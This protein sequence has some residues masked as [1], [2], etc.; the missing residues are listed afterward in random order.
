MVLF[1]FTATLFA[2]IKGKILN[3]K[4]A[5]RCETMEKMEEAIK[6]DPTL[7]QQWK[8]Q[9]EKEYNA[10]LQRQSLQKG[11]KTEA[12]EIIIPVVFH[13]VDDSATLSG[14]TDRD[15]YEQVEILN[16]AYNGNKGD[17]YQGVIPQEIYNRLG[18]I[19]LKFVLA[20][21]T[22]S[23]NLTNGIERRVNTSPDHISIKSYSSGGLD[24]WDNTKYVNVWC[25]T[26]SGSDIGLL[27]IA[28]FPFTT[29]E[30]PQGV[31]ISI[32][33]LPYT[34]SN[35]RSYYPA[36]AEGGTLAHE[37]GHYFYL[38]HTFGDQTVCNN[39]DFR[40]QSGWPL[41][42]GAG[43]EGDDTPEEKAGP[44]N[45]YFGDPSMNYS[46]GCASE[47]FGEMYGSFMNYFDDRAMFM[48]SDGMRKRVEGCIDLYRPGLLTT[49]GATPPVAVTDAFLVTVTP[50][51]IPERKAYFINNSPFT[52]TVRNTGTS[53]MNS[54]TLNVKLD[55][56]SPV[57]TV[58]PLNLA[59]G[60]DTVLNLG[61][62]NS[63]LGTH[64]MTIYTTAPNNS[65]DAFTDNDTIQSFIYLEGSSITAPFTESFSSNTF[66]PTGWQI[67]NP[68]TNNT[69]AYSSSSGYSLAG[70]AT[71][72]NFSY[73]G[74]G[75][76]DDLISPP[77][78]L[79]SADS[80]VLSFR[81]A[82]AVYDTVD[83]STWDGLE[84]YVSGDGGVTYHL[85]YKKS[86]DQLKTLSAAQT[87]AF[88]AFPSSPGNWRLENI[89][90]TPFIIP[91]KKVI[92]KFRNINGY[93][94]NTYIDDVTVSV[95]KLYNRDVL[96]VSI[97]ALPDLLCGDV[98]T[99]TVTLLSNGIDSLK[100]M[101]VNYQLDN[102]NI[103]IINWTGLLLKG[104]QVGVPLNTL[105]GLTVGNHV[106]T[107]YTSDPN[108][109]ADDVTA[110]DT[111][112][113]SF[114]VFGKV[115]TPISEGFEG[116]TFPPANWGISNQDGGITWE[117]TTNVAKTGIGSMVI[118]NYDNTISSTQKFISSIVSGTSANDSL[119]VSFDYAYAQGISSSK[120]DTLDLQITTDCGQT[121]TS[122]W[123]KWGTDLQTLADPS[124][125]TGARFT[126]L[127]NDW[128]NAKIDLS[129]FIGND[130]QV[131]FTSRENEQ[132]N[133]YIDNINIYGVIVPARLKNQGYLIYP[134]P[135]RQQFIIRNYEV[136]V[137]F[138]SASVY[139]SV[140]QLVWTKNYNGTANKEE[141][142]DLSNQARGIY[143]V[144]L[145]YTD[146][147][148][149]QRIVKD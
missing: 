114:Y 6:K 45:A 87:S 36:Y 8:I 120:P 61:N 88:A 138:Q 130:F 113:K 9:G 149:V 148:I 20:K 105:N 5:H 111:I 127:P 124:T 26:F 115:S 79:G 116:V 123:K 7:P 147:T 27:G 94:N 51:G 117:R 84:V 92:V 71:V 128:M 56:A 141:T 78:D 48:F 46:D 142:V 70:A 131:S 68:N 93:G 3:A 15:I 122:L 63:T 28:T 99:P 112:R 69:W 42:T 101:K 18:R 73:N 52:A 66:P 10:Y 22:P 44:G 33:S 102:G 145:K 57:S 98:P 32:S 39:A 75:Q 135:F 30:G 86:G 133:L 104:Q 24:A 38:W 103:T 31:V 96:P 17:A 109:L 85:A 81:V 140:G 35:S 60:S 37:I 83:V 107:V 108:G 25:G 80:S 97:S 62:I 143:I 136:P 89:N 1:L 19:P 43:P 100:S 21:R 118:R 4:E 74:V 144:K 59:A 119:F 110:N 76:L 11:T 77:I 16:Q 50:R 121:F 34:S 55:G 91:G 95:F 2:Q 47:S 54:V 132:N 53:I 90:L 146:K 126:P 106:L 65:T 139:N 41:P 14:I 129:Q 67:W 125:A 49:D 134:S 64:T 82:N 58:F 13:L 72:Q 12:S 29:T 40:I 23:G 137:T